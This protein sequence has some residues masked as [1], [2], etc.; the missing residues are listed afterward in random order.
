MTMTTPLTQLF[1]VHHQSPWI[2]NVSR[3]WLF[4]GTLAALVNSGIRGV[5]SNPTIFAKAIGESNDYDGQ[6]QDLTS[7]GKSARAAYWVMVADDIASACDLLR[8]IW[9]QGRGDGCVSVE[10]APSVAHDAE[11]T[12]RAARE[13]WSSISRP[14]VMI[15]VPA[16]D[17]GIVA[18]EQ[19][20]ATAINVNVTLIFTPQRYRQVLEA[21]VAGTER[22]A[23]L[24]AQR[25]DDKPTFGQS[26]ASFFVSRTDAALAPRLDADATEHLNYRVGSALAV[27][28]DAIRTEVGL[29]TRWKALDDLKPALQRL[30]WASVAPKEDKVDPLLYVKNLCIDDSVITLPQ[31]TLAALNDGG[32]LTNT[33]AMTLD[34]AQTIVDEVSALTINLHEVGVTLEEQGLAQFSESFETL[35]SVLAEKAKKV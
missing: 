7:V 25:N 26:V 13:L 12:I 32:D 19:L 28:C 14:N 22:R 8:P 6:L 16:T 23:D 17:A 21:F 11:A 33:V 5:T 1:G 27:Q 18:I 31:V 9:D 29:S 3:K 20:L 4:D 10:L 24:V 35:I 30:L 34:V 15:K 2:D